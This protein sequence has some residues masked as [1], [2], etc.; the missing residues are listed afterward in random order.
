MDLIP[1]QSLSKYL[2][3]NTHSFTLNR[4]P[5][6]CAL[7]RLVKEPE[8]GIGKCMVSRSYCIHLSGATLCTIIGLKTFSVVSFMRLS[9]QKGTCT[10]LRCAV[11]LRTLSRAVLKDE[12]VGSDTFEGLYCGEDK[13]EYIARIKQMCLN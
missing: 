6:Y 10:S 11:Y 1:N 3:Q 5:G 9:K 8:G 13:V 4:G 2:I 12:N 7:H